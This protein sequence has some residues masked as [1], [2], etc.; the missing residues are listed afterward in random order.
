MSKIMYYFL[1]SIVFTIT[2]AILVI[3]IAHF[4]VVVA[5]SNNNKQAGGSSSNQSRATS[6]STQ[7][8]GI[9][10][11]QENANPLA[12]APIT[13]IKVKPP[14]NTSNVSPL[15]KTNMTGAAP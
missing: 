1:I 8:Q 6:L 14:N 12:Q 5:Q 11:A 13:G 4:D 10:G 15:Q 7:G 9:P 2:V 3:S